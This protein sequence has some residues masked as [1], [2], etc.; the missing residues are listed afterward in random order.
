MIRAP[1]KSLLEWQATPSTVLLDDM[2]R[3]P[4]HGTDDFN[5]RAAPA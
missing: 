4:H 3:G 5:M 1:L 2:A